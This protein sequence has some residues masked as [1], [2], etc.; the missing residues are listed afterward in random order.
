MFRRDNCFEHHLIKR[1]VHGAPKNNSNKST[2][3]KALVRSTALQLASRPKVVLAKQKIKPKRLNILPINSNRYQ[4]ALPPV[5]MDNEAYSYLSPQFINSANYSGYITPNN[6]HNSYS[7]VNSPYANQTHFNLSYI[8]NVGT[9]HLT[10]NTQVV[11][12]LHMSAM[13]SIFHSSY[14]NTTNNNHSPKDPSPRFQNGAHIRATQ[15]SYFSSIAPAR[16]DYSNDVRAQQVQ[17]H[18]DSALPSPHY[19]EESTTASIYQEYP[20]NTLHFVN[21][22]P[23]SRF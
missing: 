6:H 22:T 15:A 13:N 8:N 3:S 12:P 1:N 14:N 7:Y 18:H 20:S 16:Y 21:A 9:S 5:K 2:G 23:E 11:T 19:Q 17:S 10:P 4:Y